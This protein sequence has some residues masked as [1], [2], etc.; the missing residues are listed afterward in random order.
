VAWLWIWVAFFR[1][2][3][4]VLRRLPPGAARERGL[5]S[6]SVA[7]VAGFLVA[8]LFEHNFGDGEV[9]MVVYALMTLPFVVDRER[10]RLGAPE[11]VS[12]GL[13]PARGTGG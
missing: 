10:S 6:A 2:G 4:R 8:G 13:A 3:R 1:E 12:A 9:V 11:R 7:A 5:V